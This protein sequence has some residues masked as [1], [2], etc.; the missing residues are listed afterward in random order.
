[1]PHRSRSCGETRFVRGDGS[2]A[3]HHSQRTTGHQHRTLGARENSCP[4]LG[5]R[6]SPSPGSSPGS[7]TSC[8]G[9]LPSRLRASG[10]YSEIRGAIKASAP[11]GL[12]TFTKVPLNATIFVTLRRRKDTKV[13]LRR[14]D[15]R[16]FPACRAQWGANH[17]KEPRPAGKANRRDSQASRP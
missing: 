6:L 15:L 7:D 13:T 11:S 14:C 12:L 5:W 8:L 10:A 16:A 2:T 3:L 1:M 17:L 9:R 4:R